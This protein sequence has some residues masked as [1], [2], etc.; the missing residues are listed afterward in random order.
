MIDPTKQQ[1]LY[2]SWKKFTGTLA[3]IRQAFG[4]GNMSCVQE[5]RLAETDEGET[6]EEQIQK[7]AH[8]FL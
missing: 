7:H 2:E 3:I 4:E 8:N 1:I 6:C 5:F